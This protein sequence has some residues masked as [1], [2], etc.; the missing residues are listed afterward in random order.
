MK[1]DRRRKTVLI[2]E[3]DSQKLSNQNLALGEELQHQIEL[4]FPTNLITLVRSYNEADLLE[5]LGELAQTGQ[6]YGTVIIIGHSS[7]EGLKIS[8]DRAFTWQ[9]T[10]NWIKPFTPK[11]AILLACQGGRWLPCAA[12]FDAVPTLN[13]ITGSPILA[14][15][16]QKHA[17]L[18][19]TLHI[20]GAKKKD[21]ELDQIIKFG[22]LLLT[23]GLM[24]SRTRTEYERGGDEEGAMWS[25]I[26][27]PLIEQLF[28]EF[29]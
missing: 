23:K 22:N 12:L 28:K 29:R 27:E 8:A 2:L 11:Q 9:A 6:K 21:R 4:F 13:E 14:N 3:C 15:K 26:A 18:A 25:D 7:R 24:F 5:S 17:V 19:A 1:I 10:G 16:N 20:L